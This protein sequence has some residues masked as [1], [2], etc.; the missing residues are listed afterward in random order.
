VC[1]LEGANSTE[2][3][4][5]TPH[6]VIALLDEQQRITKKGGTMRL[7]SQHCRLLPGRAADAYGCDQIAERHR[8]RYEFNND[9]RDQLAAAGLAFTGISTDKDLVEI[10]EIP[11]HPW[12]VAVQ[13][14]PEFK[15]KP[16]RA[17]P[18][19]REFLRAA[20]ARAGAG[21]SGGR[22]V[23]STAAR[24]QGQGTP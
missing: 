23:A 19:F 14:H 17:H 22:T 3:D 11:D 8:H 20:L 24:P 1:G 7:G 15:S 21:A 18:L 5:D 16:T 4:A 2:I 10:V 6:P 12:F 13:F 9:Y